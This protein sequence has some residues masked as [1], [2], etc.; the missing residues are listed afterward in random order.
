MPALWLAPIAWIVMINLG[1]FVAIWRDK[2]KAQKGEWRIREQTLFLF[3]ALGGVWGMLYGMKTFRHK[4]RKFSFIAVSS[5]LVIL[6]LGYYY[7]T[8]R[9]WMV[10][11]ESA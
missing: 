6:N 11:S 3:G 7:G 9:L 2:R 10:L 8:W 1:A 5:L 4:T